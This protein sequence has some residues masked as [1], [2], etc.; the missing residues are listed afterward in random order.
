MA[1]IAPIG[2]APM[3]LNHHEIFAQKRGFDGLE[4]KEAYLACG[5][6]GADPGKSGQEMM[7]RKGMK[8]RVEFLRAARN[9]SD[10]KRNLRNRGEILT[11]V[12][13]NAINAAEDKQY[14]AST[15]A[16]VKLGDA[17]HNGMF[18]A[19]Q[20]ETPAA[21]ALKDASIETF[22]AVAVAIAKELGV[23]AQ[24]GI[25]IRHIA[26]ARER[27][28]AE[29]DRAA[30]S[31]EILTDQPLPAESEAKEIPRDGGEVQ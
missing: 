26:A 28:D 19:K 20:S 31:V 12:Q 3:T 2:S 29:A 22:T 5:G 14:A 7:Q 21:E 4:C 30:G 25:T 17:A 18:Q 16:W 6:E 15:N 10:I 11:A 24:F 27:N 8:Q 13:E 23:E 9:E 1:K